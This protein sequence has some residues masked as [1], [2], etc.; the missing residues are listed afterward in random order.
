MSEELVEYECIKEMEKT[1]EKV[2]DKYSLDS[3]YWKLNITITKCDSEFKP[4]MDKLTFEQGGY[5]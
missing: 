5:E 4:I 3:S 2:F 1:F